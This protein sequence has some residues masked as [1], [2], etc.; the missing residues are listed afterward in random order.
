MGPE[1]VR[2]SGKTSFHLSLTQTGESHGQRSLASYIRPW[3][4][5]ALDMTE[6]AYPFKPASGKE[7]EITLMYQSVHYLR[8]E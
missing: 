2:V 1:V 8:E 6:H 4:C 7:D 3:G 5:E